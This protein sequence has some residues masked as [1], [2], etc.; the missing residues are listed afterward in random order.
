M[1]TASA[2]RAATAAP[3][4]DDG[5]SRIVYAS[6]LAITSRWISFVPS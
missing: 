6:D 5:A 4:G 1:P 2:A 3:R